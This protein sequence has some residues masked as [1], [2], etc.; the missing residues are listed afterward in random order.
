MNQES[1]NNSFDAK[2]MQVIKRNQREKREGDFKKLCGYFESFPAG[3]SRK[4]K[5]GFVADIELQPWRWIQYGLELLGSRRA[6]GTIHLPDGQEGPDLRAYLPYPVFQM[7][8]E[9]FLKGMWLYQFKEC[10]D[11]NDRS[12][13]SIETRHK[14]LRDIKNI[15]KAH[16]LIEIIQHVTKIA[17]YS[18]DTQL[19]QF[20]KI[21]TGICQE[22]YLPVTDSKMPWADERYP[23]RFY[24]DSS[25]AAGAELD[26]ILPGPLVCNAVI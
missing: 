5:G 2:I 10:R 13:V 21:V 22:Y 9:V 3:Y 12:Y 18:E 16:D 26:E 19:S 1:F 25:K 23:K 6:S 15:S 24:D 14:Y 4:L 17:C 20:L 7:G 8:T 11:L